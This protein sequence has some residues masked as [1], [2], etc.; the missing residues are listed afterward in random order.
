MESRYQR[1]R[2]L[3]C[4]FD[5][6]FMFT[7]APNPLRCWATKIINPANRHCLFSTYEEERRLIIARDRGERLL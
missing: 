2:R 4:D 5:T 7:P 1:V 6:I 3:A